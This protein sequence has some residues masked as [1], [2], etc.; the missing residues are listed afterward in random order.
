MA[1]GGATAPKPNIETLETLQPMKYQVSHF[2]TGVKSPT[3]K[4]VS[5]QSAKAAV[6]AAFPEFAVE[7]HWQYKRDGRAVTRT[8]F[9][10][11]GGVSWGY[12]ITFRA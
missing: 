5:A 10:N 7:G 9:K 1:A 4:L 11:S 3:V 6:A 8:N 12:C 2:L